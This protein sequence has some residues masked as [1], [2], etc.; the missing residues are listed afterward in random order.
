MVGRSC[1]SNL[2]PA[3]IKDNRRC[4]LCTQCL[5]S[6]P[7]KNLRFSLRMPCRDLFG[8]PVFTWAGM[9]FLLVVAAFVVYEI[10]SEWSSSKAVLTWIPAQVARLLAVDGAAASLLSAVVMFVFY[11]A[12]FL[13]CVYLLIAL[14]ITLT[15]FLKSALF[16]QHGLPVRI[17]VFLAAGVYWVVFA[18]TIVLWRF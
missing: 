12:V 16:R 13:G 8:S 14:T 15:I 1:T 10:L 3:K 6:C 11:P 7:Y 5:K 2:Y 17:G 4:L 9:V 18:V